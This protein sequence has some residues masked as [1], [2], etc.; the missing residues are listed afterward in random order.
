MA[1]LLLTPENQIQR[2]NQLLDNFSSLQK[3]PPEILRFKPHPKSWNVLEVLEHLSICYN[4]YEEKIITALK[5]STDTNTGSWEYQPGFWIRFVIEG[6]R[7]KGQH[8]PFKLKTLKKFEPHMVLEPDTKAVQNVMERFRNNY[9][10]LKRNIKDSRSKIMDHPRFASAIGSVVSF[11]LPESFELLRCH[12]E[13]HMIHRAGII[14]SQ[15]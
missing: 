2:L 11:R 10:A 6:Q 12:A 1:K 8:R 7:P 3:L 4:Q 14:A 13:R 9:L 15:D 5:A